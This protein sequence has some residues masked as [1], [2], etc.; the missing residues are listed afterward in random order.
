MRGAWYFKHD[1]SAKADQ[2][3][4]E[5]EMEFGQHIGYSMWFRLLEAMGEA[6]GT[7]PKKKLKL[8]AITMQV[9]YS[10]LCEFIKFCITIGLITETEECYFNDRFV[11]EYGKI[12]HVSEQ[13][14]KNANSRWDKEPDA[15]AGADAPAKQPQKQTQTKPKKEPTI[16]HTQQIV[17]YWNAKA[18]KGKCQKVTSDVKKAIAKRTAEYTLEE[19][20][21]TI[22]NYQAVIQ[23]T[24]CSF[25]YVWN[26]IDFFNRGN[27]FPSFYGDESIVLR[28]KNGNSKEHETAK[29]EPNIVRHF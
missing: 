22:T 8:Y 24:N 1:Y 26:I 28:Y 21:S 19:I 14:S 18:V 29:D 5:L 16:D 17:D 3:V 11:Q 23:D 15:V 2:K 13:N 7:M 25:S 9:E 20:Y 27:A 6:G 10:V 12:R 4:M